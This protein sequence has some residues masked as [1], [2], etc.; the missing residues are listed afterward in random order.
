MGTAT[1]NM[2]N[3]V[4]IGLAVCSKD[5]SALS[6]AT[7]DNVA[8]TQFPAPWVN[9][10]IGATGPVGT[11]EFFGGTYTVSGSGADIYGTADAF[12]FVRQPLSGDG[13]IIARVASVQNT[14]AWAKAGVMIRESLNTDSK[15]AI[16]EISASAGQS[17]FQYRS[18]TAG[19]TNTSAKLAA[20]APRWVR[21][22]RAGNLLA[23]SISTDGANWTPVGSATF[24]MTSEIYIG[25]AVTSHDNAQTCEAVFDSVIVVP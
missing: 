21:L 13:S 18:A 9:E 23:G 20:S 15:N 3:S 12:R 4:S 2:A 24:S 7:F 5:N 16:M 25:L 14:N 19:T 1:L 10:N 22:T 8:I 17:C 11:A 6:A